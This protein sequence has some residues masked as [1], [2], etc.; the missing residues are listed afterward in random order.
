MK[1]ILRFIVLIILTAGAIFYLRQQPENYSSLANKIDIQTN[2][3]LTSFGITDDN[4]IKNFRIQKRTQTAKWI[5]FIKEIN[6]DKKT[7]DIITEIK[8]S[9]SEFGVEV[10]FDKTLNLLTVSKNGNILNKILFLQVKPLKY[11]AAIIIDDVGYKKDELENFLSLGVPLTFSILPFEKYSVYLNDKLKK[12]NCEFLLHQPMEP[13][14]YPKINPGKAAI[15]LN[16]SA[17]EIEK[18][19]KKNLTNVDGA[20]GMNNHMGSA[21]TQDKTKMEEF[22]KVVKEKNLIFV[23]SFTSPKSTAYK[24][25]KAMGIPTL[26]NEIFLDIEDNSEYILKQLSLFKKRIKKDGSCIAIGHIHKKNL[27]PA[28]SKIIPEFEKEEI[29]FLTISEYL[30]SQQKSGT[31]NGH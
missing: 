19:V 25:A 10:D 5:Q 22:L 23:D 31:T 26:Q 11:K 3:V 27:P 12:Q 2:K 6:T 24:T 18:K 13:E 14:G 21:F 17:E 20:I 15:L 30:K 1:K 28:L 9:L 16:M 8:I 7:A 29:T 4:I